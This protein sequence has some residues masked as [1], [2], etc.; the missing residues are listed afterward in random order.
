MDGILKNPEISRFFDTA[1]E[2]R[3]EP[4]I[5]TSEGTLYRPDRVLVQNNRATLIDY[6]TGKQRNGHGDQVIQIC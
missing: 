6:K 3:N 2:V 1:F 4:E 5:L